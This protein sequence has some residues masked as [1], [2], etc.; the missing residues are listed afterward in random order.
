MERAARGSRCPEGPPLAPPTMSPVTRRRWLLWAAA[1]A[2]LGPPV[3][4]ARSAGERSSAAH[5]ALARQAP[6]DVDPRGFLISEKY[7]GVRAW[8]DGRTL[9]FRSGLPI[10]APGWFIAQLPREPVDGE[11]WIARG[12]FEA[13]SGIVR[14]ARPV[15]AEWRRVRYMLFEMPHA[16]GTF[17]E[18]SMAL[19]T[20]VANSGFQPLVAVAQSTLSDRS[21]LQRRL[22]EVVRG[23][24]EGLVLHRA[25]APYLSGRSDAL[26]KLKLQQDAEAVVTGHIA[27]RGKYAGVLGALQVRSDD[28][29]S[30][31]LGSGLSD[32]QRAEPPPIGTVVTYTYRGTTAAGT[33]RFA[34]FLRVRPD[35]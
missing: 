23:G 35:I 16:A 6:A 5:L 15:D 26:L 8:W 10:A 18:R 17:A 34:T 22:A 29:A 14:K 12:Q 2:S 27:G 1:S 32:A 21:A 31:A 24:G 30:F 4:S 25:D 7:D 33:P 11:L 28:G 20:L 3:A 13:V 19:H 9:R